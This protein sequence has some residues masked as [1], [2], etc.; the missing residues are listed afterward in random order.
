MRKVRVFYCYARRDESFL[1]DLFRHLAPLRRTG[2]MEDWHDRDMT[3][4]EE[5]EQAISSRLESSDIIIVLVTANFIASEYCYSKEMKRALERHEQNAARVIPVIVQPVLWQSLPFGKLQSLPRD[6]RPVT[7]WTNRQE[8][9][10]NVADGVFHA[11][12]KLLKEGLHSDISQAGHGLA[13]TETGARYTETQE[14]R[15]LADKLPRQSRIRSWAI[16]TSLPVSIVLALSLATYFIID[17][18][19]G[20]GP[21]TEQP[22]SREN[23]LEADKPTGH[24]KEEILS[25][26]DPEADKALRAVN[27][28]EAISSRGLILASEDPGVGLLL[29]AGVFKCLY[30]KY[31]KRSDIVELALRQLLDRVES[32][33]TRSLDLPESNSYQNILYMTTSPGGKWLAAIHG[34][35]IL[36]ESVSL[37]NIKDSRPAPLGL[38]RDDGFIYAVAFG[39]DGNRIAVTGQ[40]YQYGSGRLNGTR[41]LRTDGGDWRPLVEIDHGRDFASRNI[42]FSKDN[43]V[44]AVGG[45]SGVIQLWDISAN[46]K[47]ADLPQELDHSNGMFFGGSGRLLMVLGSQEIKI[48]DLDD[49][50]VVFA[51]AMHFQFAALSYDT[52]R[53]A[54]Y[55]NDQ[56]IRIYRI[57]W[58]G[59]SLRPEK[60]ASVPDGFV[61]SVFAYG[62]NGKWLAGFEAGTSVELT[63]FDLNQTVGDIHVT[64]S[65]EISGLGRSP[66]LVFSGDGRWLAAGVSSGEYVKLFLVE[67]G[68]LMSLACVDLARYARQPEWEDALKHPD[69]SSLFEEISYRDIC[70]W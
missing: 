56:T 39:P 9:W 8:A 2:M 23:E 10:A 32:G 70:D 1:K 22:D 43:R 13:F 15:S 34:H 62:P 6:A 30:E 53:L 67:P 7:K 38:Y 68:D 60:E 57:D 41:I 5:W 27:S 12:R 26:T 45:G 59:G 47:I 3:A 24:K 64:L 18:Q 46:K 52:L 20:E 42:A 14:L 25:E 31:G 55:H 69:L 44:L 35:S 4:G 17:S 58:V 50:S 19:I 16:K 11:I 33:A 63:L 66:S 28:L 48:L 65:R 61:K 37:W 54:V 51:A 40:F 29:V 36:G 49:L 21:E